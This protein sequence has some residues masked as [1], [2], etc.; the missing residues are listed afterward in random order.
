MYAGE[1]LERH[2]DRAAF[3][4]A[5]TGEVVTYREFEGRANQLARLL[6][7]H[8]LQRL[9]HYSIFMENN[10]RYLEACGAGQRAGLY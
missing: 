4:M 5:S 10:D 9:D 7:A 8:G 3:I 1:Y 6:R 2:P